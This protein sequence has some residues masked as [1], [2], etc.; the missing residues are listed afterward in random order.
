MK[1]HLVSFPIGFDFQVGIGALFE[2]DI[3]TA[4][5]AGGDGIPYHSVVIDRF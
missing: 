5:V 1:L 4:Q 3:K 2:P